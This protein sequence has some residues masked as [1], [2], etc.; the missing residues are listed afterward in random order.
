MPMCFYSMDRHFIFG[1]WLGWSWTK[2]GPKWQVFTAEWLRSHTKIFL[3]ILLAL[4]QLLQSYIGGERAN[5]AVCVGR[6]ERKSLQLLQIFQIFNQLCEISFRLIVISKDYCAHNK[7][8][9]AATLFRPIFFQEILLGATF[10]RSH[11]CQELLLSG[12]TFEQLKKRSKYN[13][14]YKE[15][16]FLIYHWPPEKLTA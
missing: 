15:L 14:F 13:S 6:S 12:A 9:G 7:I 2:S 11:F 10:V 1:F 5:A 4:L 8:L 16:T 3:Q